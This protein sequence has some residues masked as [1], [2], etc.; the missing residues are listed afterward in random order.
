MTNVSPS[1]QPSLRL[2]GRVALVTGG[3][4]GLGWEISQAFA[5]AGA[6]VIVSSRHEEACEQAAATLREI[7]GEAIGIRCHVGHWQD[8][9]E[10]AAAAERWRDGVDVL[11][12]NAGM[13]PRY[14]HLS[15]VSEELWDK[16]IGVNMKGPFRLSA[17]IGEAMKRRGR[18]SIINVSSTGSVRPTE[19]IVPYA[20][21]KAGLNAMTAG[22]AGAL[23]PEVRVNCVM[24]GPFLTD[25]SAHWDLEA[26]GRTART[27]PLRRGGQPHEIAGAA[28][29]LASDS[30]TFT[31]GATIVVDG[32]AQWSQ[33]GTGEHVDNS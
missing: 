3:T 5:Q 23:G 8:V 25:I 13:A 28:L 20:A 31:T 32:G 24:P 14:E 26:F 10:L 12:N 4:R 33:A 22:L 16:V 7:G 18:G 9:D 29:Y 30:S 1:A 6:A 27:F 11:V 21:A 2:D 17:L 19:D 15:D